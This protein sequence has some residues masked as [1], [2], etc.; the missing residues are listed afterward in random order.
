MGVRGCGSGCWLVIRLSQNL[1]LLPDL[2]ECVV[3]FS[4]TPEDVGSVCDERNLMPNTAAVR[5]K[6]L[7]RKAG[8]RIAIAFCD[9]FYAQSQGSTPLP[10][11]LGQQEGYAATNLDESCLATPNGPVNIVPAQHYPRK[12][13]SVSV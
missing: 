13:L 1:R 12:R 9:M 11:L 6:K 5:K 2:I 4:V 10:Q 8:N 3:C 7:M